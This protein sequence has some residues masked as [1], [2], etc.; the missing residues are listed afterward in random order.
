M[1]KKNPWKRFIIIVSS[2]LV[3]I[4][5]C[6]TANL[7][8]N[9]MI[10]SVASVNAVNGA[11]G[12]NSAG[13]G[14]N[15][16]GTFV[17]DNNNSNGS[18][19]ANQQG[20]VPQQG[21]NNNQSAPVNSPLAYDKAQLVDFYN[22]ALKKSYTY[23]LNA[24]KVENVSV[25]VGEV[26]IKAGFS[27]DATKMANSIIA[28][29]T[30]NND[31][32]QTKSF[33]NGKSTDDGTS[34]QQFVLPTNL[35]ADAVQDISIAQHNGGYKMVIKLKSETCAHNGT[36]KYNASCT[37][38]LDVGVINFGQA[39]TIQQCTFTYPGTVLT[40]LI[41]SQGR[42]YGVQTEM[43]LHVSDAKATAV[44]ATITVATIDGKWVCK[45]ELKFL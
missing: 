16:A 21:G 13:Q 38:P 37:W 14:N 34:I 5:V 2:L 29:N 32:K 9:S 36:A 45:N 25:E 22:A 30:K 17:P 23:K 43:P 26:T 11:G 15:G 1:K 10:T 33:V 41:D 35:Y 20:N 39:V 8:T 6:A 42:V 40:A 27:V 4:M 24:T 7:I 12:N 3:V 44:G 19:D 18:V 31:V 28:N